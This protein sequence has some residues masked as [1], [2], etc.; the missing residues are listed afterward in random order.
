MATTREIERKFLVDAPP[1]ELPAGTRVRQGYVALEGDVEVRVREAGDH[2][3]TVKGG[4]GLERV[5][6]I[7]TIDRDQF[8]ALWELSEGRRVAKRR[9]VI[10]HEGLRIEVDV[11]E[12]DLAGLVVAE[13]EF[14]TPEAAAAFV[15]PSWLGAEVTG[16]PE[17]TNA[18]LAVRG[19]PAAVD[20]R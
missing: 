19:R 7:R 14:D 3:I 5:E 16:R 10:P 8:E 9:S 11:F 12:G 18:S 4:S 15:P 17:W 6:V 13:V 2:T 1:A 20:R